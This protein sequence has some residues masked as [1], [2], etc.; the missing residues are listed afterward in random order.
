[1]AEIIAGVAAVSAFASLADLCVKLCKSLNEMRET[2]VDAEGAITALNADVDAFSSI[3]RQMANRLEQSLA[4]G[5]QYSLHAQMDLRNIINSCSTSLLS[6]QKVLGKFK[7][8]SDLVGNGKVVNIPVIRMKFRWVREEK[9]IEKIQQS[10]EKQKS[11]LSVQL[12][13][14]AV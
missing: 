6:L 11:T 4:K 7:D 9:R 2:F 12:L 14:I 8:F 1:M 10:L 3:L 5:R 13:V